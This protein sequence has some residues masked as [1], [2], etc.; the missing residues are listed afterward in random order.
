MEINEAAPKYY[1]KMSPSD[2]LEWERNQEYKHEYIGGEIFAMAGA[3][4]NHNKILT[5]IIVSAGSYLKEKSCNIYPS[6]LR[7]A[8]KSKSSFFYPDATIVCGELLFDDEGLKDTVKNPAVIFEILSP[9]TED[10]DIGKKLFFYMQIDSLQQYIIVDSRSIH[11]RITT[12]MENGTWKFTELS[13]E[14]NVLFINSI[15]FELS[16]SEIYDGVKF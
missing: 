1:P 9:S 14:N 8:V 6:D 3:S 4:I 15:Q 11:V 16:L 7:I 12:K 10:Y 13:E 5:N 2:F